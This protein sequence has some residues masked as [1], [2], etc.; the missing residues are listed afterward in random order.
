MVVCHS[1]ACLLWFRTA[2]SLARIDRLPLVAPPA[3]NRV[4]EA[5]ASFRLGAFDAAAVRSSVRG[6][7]RIACSDADPYN[8][9]GAQAAYGTALGVTADVIAGAGHVTPESGYGPWPY[10]EAWC[11]G[12]PLR[13]PSRR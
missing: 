8:P 4:P 7:I 2:G 5:G 1:L 9:E 10:A 12:E 11:T 13:A 6:E 3:S